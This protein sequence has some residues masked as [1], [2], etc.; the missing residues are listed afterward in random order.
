MSG[1]PLD[2]TPFGSVLNAIG[3]LYWL[4][5]FAILGFALWLPKVLWQKIAAVAIAVAAV[6]LVFV[7]PAQTRLLAQQQQHKESNAKLDE[8]MALFKKRCESAGEK[9]ARTVEN[10]DGVVWMK[11]REPISNADNFADQFKLNDPYGQD[12]GAADCLLRLLRVPK[13][14]EEFSA[15]AARHIFGYRYVE[16]FDPTDQLRYRYVGTLRPHPDWTRDKISQRKQET[17]RDLSRD[18]YTCQ[19]T[20][21]PVESRLFDEAIRPRHLIGTAGDDYLRGVPGADTLDGAGGNDTLDGGVG[22]DVLIGGAGDDTYWVDD[23]GEQLIED[24]AGGEDSVRSCVSFALAANVENLLLT[25]YDAID[26]SGNELAN[27]IIGNDEGNV[28]TGGAGNDT[29]TGGA[30]DDTYVFNRGDGQDVVDDIDAEYFTDTLRLGSGIAEADLLAQQS[31]DDLILKIMN[32]TDQ[33]TLSNYY[34]R[35]CFGTSS[36]LERIEF[37]DGMV[38]DKAA[39]DRE[40]RMASQ[41]NQLISAMAGFVPMGSTT[42]NDPKAAFI[43]MPLTNPLMPAKAWM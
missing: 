11:W 43:D 30:G 41:V 6:Y 17:G 7:R 19:L 32:S 15:E 34:T 10:V 35:N 42:L 39:I 33:L 23:T 16:S 22:A 14:M 25:G 27:V 8:A 3:W 31:G 1:T 12:C 9:I 28:L 26:G 36:K 4:V 40:A 5:A 2:L 21:A 18:S 20:K 38:W 13:G 29:L 37:G 24:A